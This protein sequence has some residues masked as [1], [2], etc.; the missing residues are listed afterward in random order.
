MKTCLTIVFASILSV[1]CAQ[2]PFPD[3]GP[4]F[5]DTVLPRIDLFL[6]PDSLD[7]LYKP[8]DEWKNHHYPATFIFDN[9][10]IRDTLESVGFR[11]RGN[12]SRTAAKKSFKLSF[13]T[14]EPGRR[15][16]GLEKMNLNGEHNDPSV[17]RS[18]INWDLCR[19]IGIPA[20][21][22]N[23]VQL[24]INGE[25]WGLY[26]HVEHVDEVF[27]QSRFGNQ[28]GNLYKCLYPADLVFKGTDPDLYKE[29]FWGRRAYD[30]RTNQAL[31]DYSDL[32]HFIEVLNQTPLPQLPCELEAVFNV[33]T[34]LKAIALDVLTGNWDGPIYN[35]NNFYLYK[36]TA[37]GQ[38]EYIPYDLDNTLGIDWFGEDWA[39]RDMYHW[40]HPNEARPLYSRILE[41]PEYRARYSYYMTQILQSVYHPGIWD[42]A[43]D[44]L[45]DRLSDAAKDD[46]FRPLDYGFTYDDFLNAFDQPIPYNHVAESIRSFMDKR[47]NACLNQLMPENIAP[48]IGRPTHNYPNEAQDIKIRARVRDDIGVP[49]VEICYSTPGQPLLCVPAFDDGLHDDDQAGDGIFGAILPALHQQ[50]TLEYYIQATDADGKTARQPICQNLKI[51]L[52]PINPGIVIN[53]VMP[54]NDQTIAD[55]YGEFDDW[56]ELYNPTNT[57]VFLGNYFLSDNPDKPDKW[58]LP[59]TFLTPNAYLLVWADKDEA[60]GNTHANFKLSADGEFV[61]IFNAP[62]SQFALIDGLDF[63]AVAPD[64]AIGRLPN[65]TGDFQFVFPTPGASNE[66]VA[67]TETIDNQSVTPII[68]PNPA[69]NFVEIETRNAPRLDFR[70]WVKNA[71]GQVVFQTDE[72]RPPTPLRIQTAGWPEGIYFVFFEWENGARGAQKLVIFR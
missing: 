51:Y 30:L 61:G 43:L 59:E 32:A 40:A 31:D 25:Y 5:D 19:Q 28:D 44:Q 36:N 35:K 66:P 20:S 26:V 57:P 49:A 42:A 34:Y 67:T 47:R 17:A 23:H 6:S 65:G 54:K 48:I 11:F 4:V 16:Y 62:E 41:V 69:R 13:N 18:K 52:G 68:K 63:G 46:P 24:Y 15:F 50:T 38:F 58:R 60:Q 45:R 22:A 8:G 2:T 53:E 1:L 14:Y 9:G 21:R 33:D 39:N 27:V 29:V 10:T 55:P 72:L 56:I 70:V 12:T 3:P 71:A 7:A 37:T 64:Q